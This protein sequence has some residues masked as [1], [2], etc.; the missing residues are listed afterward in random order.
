M[1]FKTIKKIL[2]VLEGPDVVDLRTNNP[3]RSAREG[4]SCPFVNCYMPCDK[5]FEYDG[6]KLD[7]KEKD[8]E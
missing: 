5:C 8:I 1:K 3:C 6:N 7:Q 2:K 4:K